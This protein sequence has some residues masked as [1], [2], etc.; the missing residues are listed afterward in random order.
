MKKFGI[1]QPV[2]GKRV[3]V[4]GASVSGIT[5]L[6]S[7]DLLKLVMIAIVIATPAGWWAMNNWLQ[8]YQ[9][10]IRLSWWMFALASVIGMGIAILTLGL[11]AARA[12]LANP[13]KTLKSE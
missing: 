5:V 4:M 8:D 12:A 6:L 2:I 10:R 13:A 11:Q 7:K 3:K 1:T 9:Y